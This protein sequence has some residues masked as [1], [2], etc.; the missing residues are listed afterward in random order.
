[1]SEET[2]VE[3][4]AYTPERKALP[5]GPAAIGCISDDPVDDPEADA[6]LLSVMKGIL[7]EMKAQTAL[8]KHIAG[9]AG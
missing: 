9:E 1:M 7:R 6:S 4:R 8:L 2:P 3:G 5:A